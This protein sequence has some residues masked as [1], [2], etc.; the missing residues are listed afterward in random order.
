MHR[1]DFELLNH[2]PEPTPSTGT[3]WTTSQLVFQQLKIGTRQTCAALIANTR[4]D[5][6][7]CP[8]TVEPPDSLVAALKTKGPQTGSKDIENLKIRIL[9]LYATSAPNEH[10]TME[11]LL[12][13]GR[14]LSGRQLD[15]PN[16]INAR[17]GQGTTNLIEWINTAG[18]LTDE[19]ILDLLHPGIHQH[20]V[21]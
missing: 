11:A 9:S 18:D 7:G 14:Q 5:L 8:R 1:I 12:M 2:E 3:P 19:E 10:H 17:K 21:D 15:D 16:V 20:L 6:R 4:F 13:P